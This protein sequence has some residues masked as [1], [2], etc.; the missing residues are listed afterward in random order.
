[1]EEKET[2][3][4]NSSLIR[5]FAGTGS[6]RS[7]VEPQPTSTKLLPLVVRDIE[8]GLLRM[9]YNEISIRFRASTD[10]VKARKNCW[11]NIGF[12]ICHENE[13]IPDQYVVSD[14]SGSQFRENLLEVANDWSESDEVVFA[15][16]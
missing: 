15:R 16:A 3:L 10:D 5:L 11:R 7:A 2:L 12:I 1:M 6:R 14:P 13:F 9:A 4:I 8:N